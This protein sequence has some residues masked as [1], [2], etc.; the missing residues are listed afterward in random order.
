MRHRGRRTSTLALAGVPVAVALLVLAVVVTHRIGQSDPTTASDPVASPRTTSPVRPARPAG[1][2]LTPEAPRSVRLPSGTSVRVRAVSTHVDGELAVPEAVGEAGWW[3]GGSRVGDP[4]GS[5]LVAAHIDSVREGLGPF[6]ELLAVRPGQRVV[7]RTATL[8]QV[9]RV[10]SL[11]LVPQGSLAKRTWIF[12][13]S[14]DRRLT[15]VTCAPP[16]DRGRGG[17]QR[18]AVVVAVPIGPPARRA[19]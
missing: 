15:L 12:S 10:R 11:R 16:Y 19:A 13:V 4:F 18:L 1:S 3:R 17:Y 9:F 5:I 6:G 8:R 7:V 2:V 14:G